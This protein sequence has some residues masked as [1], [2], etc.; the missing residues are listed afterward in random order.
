MKLPADFVLLQDI[1]LPHIAKIIKNYVTGMHMNIMSH[2]PSSSDLTSN[3]N[4][5]SW[6]RNQIKFETMN[7][8]ENVKKEVFETWKNS[9]ITLIN[10]CIELMPKRFQAV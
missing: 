10:K 3:H 8:L 9:D 6:I 2:P 1:V 5:L 4:I 7:A